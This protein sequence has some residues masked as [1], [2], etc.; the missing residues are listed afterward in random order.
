MRS[1]FAVR[2]TQSLGQQM[3]NAPFGINGLIIQIDLQNS[4]K[5]KYIM[6]EE[7]IRE[8]MFQ[9]INAYFPSCMSRLTKA[10]YHLY[11][12]CL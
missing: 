6:N 12:G 2:E 1:T 11:R 4:W 10:A 5:N 7:F 8:K 3:L 9:Y